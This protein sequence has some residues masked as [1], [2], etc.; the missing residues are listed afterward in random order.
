MSQDP[1]RPACEALIAELDHIARG[2]DSFE[3]GLPRIADPDSA[4]IEE[5]RH[6]VLVAFRAQRAAGVREAN[7]RFKNA[8]EIEDAIVWCEQ[9]AKELEG[10]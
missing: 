6:A 5:L 3:F 8:T 1:I 10:T 7:L 4:V 9:R 2:Y